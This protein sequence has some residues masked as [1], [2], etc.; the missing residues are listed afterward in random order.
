M[1]NQTEKRTASQRIDD[2][3]RGLM[4]LHQTMGNMVR[5]LMTVKE[6]IK[7]LGNKLDSVVQAS[8][9]GET[10]ND[11]VIAKIMVENNVQELKDKVSSLIDQGILVLSEEIEANSFVVGRELSEDGDVKNPRIQ[12]VVSQ[13]P[14]E[15][16]DKFPGSKVGQVLDLQEGKWKFEVQEVYKIQTPE[17]PTETQNTQSEAQS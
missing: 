12:F 5:D 7:L 14:E 8:V 17:L 15:V 6:A 11:D 1:N 4:G 10:I 13:L 16:K 3:E 9:R 2:M